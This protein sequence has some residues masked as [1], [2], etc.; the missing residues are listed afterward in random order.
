[1]PPDRR[2][3]HRSSTNVLDRSSITRLPGC[4]DGI[5]SHQPDWTMQRRASSFVGG[6]WRCVRV[7]DSQRISQDQTPRHG[8]TRRALT[9]PCPKIVSKSR[10]REGSRLYSYTAPQLHEHEI[11]GS[12][13]SGVFRSRWEDIAWSFVTGLRQAGFERMCKTWMLRLLLYAYL[14]DQASPMTKSYVRA[15]NARRRLGA[16]GLEPRSCQPSLLA[17]SSYRSSP[18]FLGTWIEH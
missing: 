17:L 13:P 3:D 16:A 4:G 6:R 18:L 11:P 14:Y 5:T 7:F 12:G 2:T 15:W 8:V 1:V 10:R 9:Q